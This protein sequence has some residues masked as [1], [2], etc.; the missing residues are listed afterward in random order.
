MKKKYTITKFIGEKGFFRVDVVNNMYGKTKRIKDLIENLKELSRKEETNIWRDIA[1]RLDKPTKNYSEVNISKIDRYAKKNEQI[2]VPGKVLGAGTISKEV[3][4]ASLSFSETA[5]QKINQTGGEA[6][7]IEEMMEKNP[8]GSE[9]KI[10][11]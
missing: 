7:S 10:I 9:I 3:T 2:L 11:G 6:I 8:E 4:V 1:N 5:E